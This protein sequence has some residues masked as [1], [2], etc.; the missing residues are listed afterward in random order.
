[1]RT[2]LMVSRETTAWRVLPLAISSPRLV[3]IT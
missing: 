1:M 2:G 3:T